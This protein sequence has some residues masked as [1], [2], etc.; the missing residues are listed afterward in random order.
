MAKMRVSPCSS[1]PFFP[2]CN[3]RLV[4]TGVICS[5]PKGVQHEQK[6][7]GEEKI[8]TLLAFLCWERARESRVG[9]KGRSGVRC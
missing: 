6:R 4:Q 8:V 1:L 5:F 7:R 3:D 9:R 2:L